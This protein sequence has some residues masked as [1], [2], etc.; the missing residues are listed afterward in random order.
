MTA[1][2][3]MI[4][5]AL[6]IVAA[7]PAR[8]DGP[9]AE[10]AQRALGHYQQGV[11]AYR[12]GQYEEAIAAFGR[13]YEVDPA[14]ILVFNIA[15]ARWK[16]GDRELALEAYRRYLTLDPGAANRAQVEARIQELTAAPSPVEPAPLPLAED[17]HEAEQRPLAVLLPAEPSAGSAL[18]SEPAPRVEGRRPFYRRGLFW[19]VVGAVAVGTAVAVAVAAHPGGGDRWSCADCNWSGARVR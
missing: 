15:Q 3:S 11:S 14:P 8:A 12:G 16:K 9:S 18:A 17:R 19:T 4:V 13:A 5:A 7:G 6:V 2:L 1:R 10:L